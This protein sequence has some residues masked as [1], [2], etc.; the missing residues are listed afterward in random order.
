MNNKIIRQI[1][2]CMCAGLCFLTS[3]CTAGSIIDQLSGKSEEAEPPAPPAPRVY[4]D[5]VSGT[6]AYFDANS[7]SIK[8]DDVL[9]D[10]DIVD[11]SIE[12][13]KGLLYGDEISVIYEGQMSGNDGESVHALKIT[14]AFHKQKELKSH[15]ITGTIQSFT[16]NSM[17]VTTSKNRTLTC[18]I[19]G[20]KIS[21]PDGL[22]PGKNVCL[23]VLGK[24]H[25]ISEGVLDGTL[26]TVLSISDQKDFR[27]P[28]PPA[29]PTPDPAA[30]EPSTALQKLRAVIESLNGHQLTIMPK[31]GEKALT[32]DLSVTPLF[33]PGGILPGTLVD[34]Y[35]YGQFNGESLAG[36]TIDQIR[37]LDPAALKSSD[38]E[39]YLEGTVVGLTAN[40]V[41]VQTPDGL[42]FTGGLRNV[43]GASGS[44]LEPGN[45][46]RIIIDPVLS[47]GTNIYR[48]KKIEDG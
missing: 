7:L 45:T 15:D 4:M 17:T 11:A 3:G 22:A 16:L 39:G 24:S 48:L 34:I 37:G 1:L 41:S 12:C 40:T 6:L 38:I 23:K 10:F 25:E 42:L 14:D 21:F 30:A 28:D 26:I 9:Y 44:F 18:S 29:V 19:I 5:E 43:P 33:A 35:Y 32:I 8:S 47:D 2:V 36:L 31:G 20:R 13:S 46:V 27:I